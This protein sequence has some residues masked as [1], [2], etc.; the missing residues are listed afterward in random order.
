MSQWSLVGIGEVLWDMLPSG[1]RLGGA[2]ANFAHFA[3]SLG[4]RGYVVS[5]VGEDELGDEIIA[6]LDRHGIDPRYVAI[7][8]D[9]PTGTVQVKVSAEG[10]PSYS[11]AAN[12][13]WDHI[14]WEDQLG[15]LAARADV[16][17][18]GSLCQRSELSRGTILSFLDGTRPHCLRLFDVNLRAGH[19]DARVLH[20]LLRR[21]NVLKLS[22]GELAT[23][24]EVLDLQGSEEGLL[25]ELAARYSLLLIALTRGAGGS[26][27]FAPL[28][29][30]NHPGFSTPIVDTVG[31][32]D[33]FTAAMALGLLHGW[34]LDEIGDRAN[35]LASFVCAHAGATPEIPAEFAARFHTR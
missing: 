35:R 6:R 19:Y 1:K 29:S 32:G 14:P 21:A 33:S 12:V 17:C 5:A 8:S 10:D 9:H 25:A 7:N 28:E 27:L 18:F 15:E 22:D 16:V 26:R 30:A 2:P 20:D 24:G 34:P 4:A 3:Q 23:V 31:A 13:A 11:I